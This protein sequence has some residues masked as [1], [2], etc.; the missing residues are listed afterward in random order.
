MKNLNYRKSTVLKMQIKRTMEN[1][2]TKNRHANSNSFSASIGLLEGEGYHF[3]RC[4]KI[5]ITH[6]NQLETHFT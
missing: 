3:L 1:I 4:Y 5:P 6:R 2:E